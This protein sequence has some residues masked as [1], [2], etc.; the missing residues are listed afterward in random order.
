MRAGLCRWLVMQRRFENGKQAI[1]RWNQVFDAISAESRRQLV[2]SLLDHPPE[3]SVPLPES[4]INPNFLPDP[5]KFR[6]ELLHHHLPKLADMEFVEWDTDPFVASR[7][8]R[9]DEVA[10]VFGA[11]HSFATDIPDPLVVGCQRL[12]EERRTN[13]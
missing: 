8:P 7:G 12:E 6:R 3:A 13:Y 5:E 10:V 1:E 11:L 2:V 4:A 9:F